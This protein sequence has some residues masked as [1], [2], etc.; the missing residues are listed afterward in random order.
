MAPLQS[1][2]LPL[3]MIRIDVRSSH[4]VE[5]DVSLIELAAYGVSPVCSKRGELVVPKP[6]L[7]VVI[8]RFQ[9]FQDEVAC[10]RV[11]MRVADHDP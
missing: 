2:K 4:D 11:L 1:I 7:T 5:D 10:L 6:N 8:Q 3:R 9:G